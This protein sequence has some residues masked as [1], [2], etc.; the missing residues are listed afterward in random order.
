MS[1]EAHPPRA[2]PPTSGGAAIHLCCAQGAA[3]QAARWRTAGPSVA[4]GRITLDRWFAPEF[5][6]HA[7]KYRRARRGWGS[8]RPGPT[9]TSKHRDFFSATLAVLSSFAAAGAAAQV[10]PLQQQPEVQSEPVSGQDDV[11]AAETSRPLFKDVRN[12]IPIVAYTYSASGAPAKALGVQGYGLGLVAARQD[13]LLG[14]GGTIWGSPV[15]RLTLIGDGQRNMYGNFSPSA[16]AVFRILGDRADG[17]SLGA[18]GKFKIDGFAAGP[19]HDEVETELEL[20]ALVSFAQQAWFLD[21][22]AI[23][24]RGLGDDGETDTEGHLRVGRNLGEHVRVGLDG[25]ARVRLA[26]PRYL[27]NGHTWDFAAGP[28]VLFGMQNFFGSVTA[29]PA[30]MGLTSSAIGWAALASFGGTTF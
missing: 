23:A 19:S 29:G 11:R 3:L 16:A 7:H 21:A 5:T 12:D 27:P 8:L 2:I 30:T 20:G 6:R 25:Q 24:G 4:F 15:D 28:Q 22:N 13:A 14:G 9:L 17:W 26:G 18:L 10:P 1:R